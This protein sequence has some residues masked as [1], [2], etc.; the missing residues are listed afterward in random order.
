[1]VT[2]PYLDRLSKNVLEV[3]HDDIA[4]LARYRKWVFSIWDPNIDWFPVGPFGLTF[5]KNDWWGVWPSWQMM[6]KCC[7]PIWAPKSGKNFR[8]KNW[9]S[10]ICVFD[11]EIFLCKK[12]HQYPNSNS[13]LFGPIVEKRV[14]SFSRQYCQFG[15][16]QKVGFFYL[17]PK[18]RLIPSGAV[19][20]NV[21]EKWLM[22]RLTVLPNDEEMLLTDLSSKVRKKF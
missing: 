3:F 22:G 9:F 6:K 21:R 10:Q 7:W 19:W 1:M 16:G 8:P 13:P 4:N 5:V 11:R 15:P 12:S 17:G 20:A 14:G 18:N 2:H